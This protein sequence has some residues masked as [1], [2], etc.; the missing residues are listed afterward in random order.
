[1]DYRKRVAHHE[2]A[3]V[4]LAAL[5][6]ATRHLSKNPAWQVHCSDSASAPSAQRRRFYPRSRRG[7][8]TTV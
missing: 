5:W 1:M 6:G 7:L 2:A 4:V 8:A 3:H